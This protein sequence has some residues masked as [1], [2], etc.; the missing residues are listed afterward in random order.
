MARPGVDLVRDPAD[1]ID[2]GMGQKQV[3][4]V[5][6]RHRE[7]AKGH[8]RIMALGN[9]AVHQDGDFFIRPLADMRL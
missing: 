6:Q 9:A 1:V 3:I 4:D 7:L 5:C 8:Q 2:V